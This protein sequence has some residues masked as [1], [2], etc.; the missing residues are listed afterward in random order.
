LHWPKTLASTSIVIKCKNRIPFRADW[1][2]NTTKDELVS[3]LMLREEEFLPDAPRDE[4][5]Y[6]VKLQED[7]IREE[8]LEFRF[9][10]R[11]AYYI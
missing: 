4:L 1:R 9:R 5:I 10:W 7:R 6:N 8:Y 3:G 11:S 2:I